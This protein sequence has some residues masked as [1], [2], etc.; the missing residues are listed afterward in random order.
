MTGA[1]AACV[2]AASAGTFT[3]PPSVLLRLPATSF[4]T[5]EFA[6]A[7]PNATFTAPGLNLGIISSFHD[8]T[9]F[10]GFPLN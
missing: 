4:S 1:T 8:G 9:V 6:P 7:V 2:V 5:F 10:S 3:I